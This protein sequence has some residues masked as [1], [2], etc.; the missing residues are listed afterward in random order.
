MNAIYVS[1]KDAIE[2]ISGQSRTVLSRQHVSGGDI[3]EAS[4]LTLD[5]GSV[6]FMKS[7]LAE[8]LANF[9]AE[10]AGLDAIRLTGAI[11]VPEVLGLGRDENTSFLLLEY[12]SPG[13][14][15]KEF[16]EIFAA[17]LAAMHQADIGESYGFYKIGRAHV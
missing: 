5:D 14:R 13:R 2:T 17:E 15:I 7:N 12:I 4:V 6:L 11:G 9:E 10:A 3:N 16:W 8:S 1:L